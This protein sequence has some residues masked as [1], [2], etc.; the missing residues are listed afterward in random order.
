MAM[1]LHVAAD[2][3]R[4]ADRDRRHRTVDAEPVQVQRLDEGIDHL[5]RVT[6]IHPVLEAFRQ[7][8][9]LRA[10]GSFDKTTHPILPHPN[11]ETLPDSPVSTMGQSRKSRNGREASDC[12]SIADLGA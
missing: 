12:R 4:P 11:G 1:A 5:N 3:G 6:L 10:V 2:H 9:T 7:K 8:G